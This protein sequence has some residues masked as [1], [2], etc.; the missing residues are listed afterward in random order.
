MKKTLMI[1]L[2]LISTASWAQVPKPA[3]PQRKPIAIMNATIHVG[4]GDVIEN[5]L[6]TFERGKIKNVG[7]TDRIRLDR[8]AYDIIDVEGKHV[9]P[10]FILPSSRLGLEDIG[11]VRATRDYD[12]VGTITPNVRSQ[13]AYNTDSE[14]IPTFRFNGIALAQVTPDGGLITGT[15]SIMMLDGWNWE[16]ATYQK[17][18]AIH[19]DWP[20]KTLGPRWWKGETERRPNKKYEDQVDAIIQTFKDAKAYHEGARPETNLKLQALEGVLKGDQRVFLEANR[21]RQIV[22]GISKLKELGIEKI[23]LVGGRDAYYVRDFLKKHDIP[24]ILD[25]IH[26]MPSRSEEPVDFPFRLPSLLQDAGIKVALRH[27]GMLSRGRNL[28]FYAGTAATY[29]L[30]REEALQLITR[31]PAEIMGIDDRTGTLEANKDANLFISDGDVLD[32]K[33]NK[34]THLFIQGRN[35][36]LEGKQQQLYKRFKEKYTE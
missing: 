10:G 16:D 32:M 7:E 11:A 19:V 21:A 14:M 17:D 13:I 12:E 6:I 20:S 5:G 30:T 34:I 23:V 4:N 2:V 1:I 18:D 25:N 35:V 3:E 36:E 26:R 31:N 22:A 9:Y 28:V 29:G 8:R 33:E 15:S 27:V 24:V